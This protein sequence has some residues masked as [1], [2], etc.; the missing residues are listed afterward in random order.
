M[1]LAIH[2]LSKKY[3]NRTGVDRI[4]LQ[5]AEGERIGILGPRASGKTTLLRVISGFLPPDGGF[6]RV[7]G[8]LI[9]TRDFGYKRKTGYLAEHNPLYADM[10]LPE[11]L[12]FAGRLQGLSGQSLKER[13]REVMEVCRI[14]Q[15]KHKRIKELSLGNRQRTGLAQAIVHD[16]ELLLLDEPTSGLDPGQVH[17]IWKLIRSI[18]GGKSLILA[19]ENQEEAVHLTG[20]II[21][22][23][24]G[25]MLRMEEPEKRDDR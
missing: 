10:P 25:R 20:K 2:N 7:N 11:Y 17:A 19:T 1:H 16:P 3:A 15:E 21:A 5:L 4:N 24:K 13:I 14:G 12:A 6:V 23:Q 18:S 22:L 9:K 8:V